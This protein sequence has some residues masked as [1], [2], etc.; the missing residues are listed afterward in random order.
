MRT[1]GLIAFLLGLASCTRSSEVEAARSG[2]A[3]PAPVGAGHARASETTPGGPAPTTSSP[4]AGADVVFTCEISE[5]PWWGPT[6]MTVRTDGSCEAVFGDL[7]EGPRHPF[8]RH[9]GSATTRVQLSPEDL[10]DFKRLVRGPNP[11]E[12][13]DWHRGGPW[14]W[15]SFC[16]VM[17]HR[18]SPAIEGVLRVTRDGSVR[19]LRLA[20]EGDTE[21]LTHW[22]SRLMNE[23][24][25][26]RRLE[27][28]EETNWVCFFLPGACPGPDEV[29]HP[30]VFRGPF[31][32]LLE[33]GRGDLDTTVGALWYLATPDEWRGLLERPLRDE[34]DER[35]DA[36][37]RALIARTWH[38][39]PAQRD[40][41]MSLLLETFEREYSGYP[42]L[43]RCRL[44]TAE[45]IIEL[46]GRERYKP[47]IPVLVRI[48]ERTDEFS[49]GMPALAAMG[50]DALDPLKGL[51]ASPNP[52]A[53]EIAART[54]Q[55]MLKRNPDVPP[56]WGEKLSREEQD[57]ILRR[58][59]EEFAPMIQEMESRDPDASVRG[60]ARHA[61]LRIAKGW[62]RR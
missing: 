61:R 1:R 62:S 9:V 33:T 57:E 45:Q 56:D 46:F 47:A 6:R 18:R 54:V 19:E 7:P 32:R 15:G 40:V 44:Q 8:A 24:D 37:V 28:G 30:S 14:T 26:M 59:R 36:I 21:A 41:L 27:Q 60:A 25:C 20:E 29:L 55:Q 43:P 49:G 3:T 13:T 35:V 48:I 31:E 38:P 53:R 11:V 22:I 2:D 16:S 42:R 5:Q 52:C 17:Q 51:L 39:E 34:D 4:S 10:E 50:A 23:A 58:L 12:E